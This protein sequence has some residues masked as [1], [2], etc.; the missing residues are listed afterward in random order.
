MAE[1]FSSTNCGHKSEFEFLIPH[2]R[3]KMAGADNEMAKS[4]V[5]PYI[6]SY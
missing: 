4:S 6:F 3:I 5:L 1:F 2:F